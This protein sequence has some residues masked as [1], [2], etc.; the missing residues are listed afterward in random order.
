MR[1]R[2]YSVEQ[3]NKYISSLLSGEPFLQGI[4]V[5]GEV[6]NLKYHSSGHI[7]FDLKDASGKLSAA[8]FR[9]YRGGL[10]YHMN[11]GDKV[12]AR[13]DISVYTRNGTYQLLAKQV[14][15]CGAGDLYTRFEQLKKELEEMGMFAAEYKKPLPGY[16]RHLGVVTAPTGAAVRDVI[17]ISTRRNPGIHITLFP[18]KVQG[19]GAAESVALGIERLNAIGVDA[20]I[21]GRGGGSIEDLW[22]FNEETVA[23]AIFN[24]EVPVISAVGHETDTTIA[25]FVADVRAATPSEAAELAVADVG[26][27]I[28]SLSAYRQRYDRLME[29]RLLEA[30]QR[31]D[32]IQD[33]LRLMHP[34]EKLRQNMQMLKDKRERLISVM[35][36]RMDTL[37]HRLEVAAGRLEGV[38][39]LKR[40][41]GGYSY[42]SDD[43][44]RNIRS[45][46]QVNIDDKV[47]A[48]LADGRLL[49]RIEDIEDGR[50]EH[51]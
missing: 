4:C 12:R 24:S 19:D 29:R 31:I 27:L 10:S 39:P 6:S 9:Q 14:A 2:T 28:E 45:V 49:M 30:W 50:K 48:V 38:S 51:A 5:E 11:E 21:V 3:V 25:D 18:A 35:N 13:G 23:R 33:K 46:S 36:K 1:Q 22:A 47:R 15:A 42:L 8:M 43:N 26:K 32:I 16:V 37:E 7:Y 17:R 40:L 20:M 34:A 41:Q 44:G